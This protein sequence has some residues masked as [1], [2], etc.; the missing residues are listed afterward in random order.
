MA[1]TY[2]NAAK[3]ARQQVIID[4]LSNG[5]F[6][7]TTSADAVLATWTLNATAGT[8]TNGN[9]TFSL[10]TN[11]ISATATGDA[12]KARF[13]TSG[14]IDVITDLVVGTATADILVDS[15]S[16]TIG[17]LITLGALTIAHS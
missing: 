8:S 13:R 4:L 16:F 3:D 9:V 11:Q 15:T 6:E 5:K 17:Q 12:A 1:I 10:S 7:I 2:T 14:D